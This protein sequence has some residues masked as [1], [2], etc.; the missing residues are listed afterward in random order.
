MSSGDFDLGVKVA[1]QTTTS[2][3]PS[4]QGAL[5]PRGILGVSKR[6]GPLMVK[7]LHRAGVVTGRWQSLR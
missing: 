7:P 6:G 5:S 3:F 4:L 2:N 1:I